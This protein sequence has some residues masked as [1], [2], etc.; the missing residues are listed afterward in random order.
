MRK[1]ELLQSIYRLDKRFFLAQWGL[2]LFSGLKPLLNIVM[3]KYII[4]EL[5][6]G[7][8]FPILMQQV[9][10]LAC[11][12][13]VLYL[14]ERTLNR[15]HE[16]Q[17][18]N[19]E[20]K[21]IVFMSM[22]AAKLPLYLAEQKEIRDLKWRANIAV[23]YM[24]QLTRQG[25]LIFK[26][27]ITLL[28]VGGVIFFYAPS[29]ILLSLAF[30]SLS[31][32][33]ARPMRKLAEAYAS[34]DAMDSRIFSYFLRLTKDYRYGKDLKIY[35][36]NPLMEAKAKESFDRLLEA[37]HSYFSK[38][39]LWSGLLGMATGVQGLLYFAVL[40]KRLLEGL[41]T[42]GQFSLVFRAA[43]QLGSSLAESFQEFTEMRTSLLMLA[44][45]QEFFGL[46]E[47]GDQQSDRKAS[48]ALAAK[49]LAKAKAGI[50]S[51]EIENLSF[52]YPTGEG[53]V[54]D[55]LNMTLSS[56]ERVA[57]VGKNGS[58][59]SS[60]VKLLCRFYKPSKGRILL[61]GVD[62][63]DFD[64]ES[65]LEILSPTF[66]DFNLLPIRVSENLLCKMQEEQTKE[67]RRAMEEALKKMGLDSWVHA[68]GRG[69]DVY[70]S[71]KI[72]P[73][74][75]LPSGG[76]GQK[77]ALARAMLHQGNYF[78]MDEPTAAL[79]PRSEEEIFQQILGMTTGESS[80]FISHRLSSTRYA[81]RI[82]VLD[83]GRVVEEGVHASLME[84]NGLYSSLYKA[85]AAQYQ[86]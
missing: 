5:M 67:E 63:Q 9:L 15:I 22:K 17:E 13:V 62:I 68:K 21:W 32:L 2:S 76:Q 31:F 49:A 6:G 23:Y 20:G 80:L 12:N 60:L 83:E 51:F 52:Q 58:G 74:G 59:K 33:V 39:S 18:T 79:D 24:W 82:L 28:G 3:P 48:S 75:L 61:N 1:L 81:D 77:L 11:F 78:I 72:D 46:E 71:Q 7:A 38:R 8:R 57:L 37:N 25:G 84:K 41:L 65:Y 29:F 73:D 69:P 34:R 27:V 40:G 43:L 42:V 70:V 64:H 36:A 19:F 54:L 10:L 85:Q 53:L 30:A 4:D 45:L 16:E 50:L 26:Q 35:R 47:I 55:Q 44:P 86:L 56:G 66:Q 14:G